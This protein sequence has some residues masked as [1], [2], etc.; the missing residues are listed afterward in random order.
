MW[1]CF[2]ILLFSLCGKYTQDKIPAISK[3]SIKPLI[4]YEED[5]V[6]IT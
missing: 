1:R 5:L 3:V 6:D 4:V 2:K